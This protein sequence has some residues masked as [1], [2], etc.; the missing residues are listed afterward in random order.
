MSSKRSSGVMRRGFLK[1]MTLSTRA[2]NDR[3]SDGE[4]GGGRHPSGAV[5]LPQDAELAAVGEEQGSEH[6]CGSLGDRA[7]VPAATRPPFLHGFAPAPEFAPDE[8]VG[9][10]RPKGASPRCNPKEDLTTNGIA[11]QPDRREREGRRGDD[12]RD[13]DEE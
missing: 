5:R 1:W 6:P 7:Q 11:A 12:Q 4:I 3:E 13:Q 8:V 2:P 10:D 9:D